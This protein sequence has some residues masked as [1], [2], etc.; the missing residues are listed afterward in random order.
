MAK[1]KSNADGAL[2]TNNKAKGANYTRIR[3]FLCAIIRY[4][5]KTDIV[6]H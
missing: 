6:Q 3:S 4:V 1:K 5:R 2:A